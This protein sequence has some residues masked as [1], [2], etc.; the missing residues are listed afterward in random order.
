MPRWVLDETR[1][2][3]VIV[4][5]DDP[6]A[7][8]APDFESLLAAFARVKALA[9]IAPCYVVVDL[10]GARPDA[11]RR[12][13]LVEWLKSEGLAVRDRLGAFGVVAPSTLLR[14]A[15][16]AVQW[17]FLEGD[18]VK[19]TEVFADRATAIAWARA[20]MP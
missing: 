17:F 20:Q 16:T 7:K 19:R 13:R 1:R 11:R 8:E 9:E 18:R 10:T 2:P 4:H 6:T 5:L 12:Q 15:F 14:G 3:L